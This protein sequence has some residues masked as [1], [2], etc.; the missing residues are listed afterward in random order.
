MQ[1]VSEFNLS[2]KIEFMW[3]SILQKLSG[4][5][6]C[7]WKLQ[8][9]ILQDAVKRPNSKCRFYTKYARKKNSIQFTVA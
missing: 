6:V 8:V 1:K 5:S 3:L 7:D 9:Q 4:N 2:D